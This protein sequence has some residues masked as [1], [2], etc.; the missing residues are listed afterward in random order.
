M[1]Q[2][3]RLRSMDWKPRTVV[4]LAM[5]ID[6]S[7]VVVAHEDASI[8]IWN[9]SLCSVGFHYELAIPGRDG[10]IISSLS[11]VSQSQVPVHLVVYSQLV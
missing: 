3:H 10:S 4:A 7:Q 11:G 1:F 6:Q 8:E 9:A 2:V 5:S